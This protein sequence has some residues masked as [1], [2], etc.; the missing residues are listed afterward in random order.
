MRVTHL[1]S[2]ILGYKF[3]DSYKMAQWRDDMQCMYQELCNVDNK[4]LSD[5]EFVC[6]LVTM[7]L[8][9]DHWRYLHSELLSKVC[10]AAPGML[11]SSEILGKLRDEDEGIHASND[12]PYV[13]L[14][15]RAEFLQSRSGSK[16]PHEAEVNQLTS[17]TDPT[18]KC[19]RTSAKVQCTNP[20]CPNLRSHHTINN[21]FAF[22]GGKCGDYPSWW[23]GSWDIHLHPDKWSAETNS[24]SMG[25]KK[26]T[27]LIISTNDSPS[28]SHP[29]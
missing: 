12:E 5:D 4:A 14:T 11:R 20:H 23:N 26:A 29:N 9:S 1:K 2:H 19:V 15:A 3:I 21:C 18:S 16:C 10:N 22:G 28:C 25:T 7:M 6:H 17:S 27:A 13:L 8:I 24:H